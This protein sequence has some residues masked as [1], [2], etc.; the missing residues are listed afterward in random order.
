M[1][2]GFTLIEMIAV[3]LIVGVLALATTSALAPI[4]EG[5]LQARDNADSAQTLAFATARLS[6]EFS[7]ITNVISGTARTITYDHLDQDGLLRRRTLAWSGTAGAPLT[8]DN[9]ALLDDIGD[10]EFRYYTAPG[11]PAQAAWTATSREIETSIRLVS[12]VNPCVLRI[13]PRNL[14]GN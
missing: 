9:V 10:L 2:R 1:K 14:R 8:L 12:D 5:Y 7:S 3:L 11:L 4:A 13:R 6:R